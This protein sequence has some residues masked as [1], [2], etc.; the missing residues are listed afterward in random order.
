[1][2]NGA[3]MLPLDQALAAT[4]GGAGGDAASSSGGAVAAVGAG[5]LLD[6]YR[7]GSKNDQDLRCRK[8]RSWDIVARARDRCTK[9]CMSAWCWRGVHMIYNRGLS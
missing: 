3:Q 6:G 8:L 5:G 2:G 7:W 4:E 1:M 9:V